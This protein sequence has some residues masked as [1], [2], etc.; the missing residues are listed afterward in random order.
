MKTLA[1]DEDGNLYAGGT[2]FGAGNVAAATT[3]YLARWDRTAK[4]WEARVLRRPLV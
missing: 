4:T 3:P 1:G 2:F